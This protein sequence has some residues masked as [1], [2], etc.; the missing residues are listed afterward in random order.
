MCVLL[1]E[2][3]DAYA[4]FVIEALGNTLEHV[5]VT[6]VVRLQ[7]AVQELATAPVDVVLLDLTL[8]DA[9]D[10]LG[11]TAIR[12]AAPDVPLVVLT[13]STDANLGSRVIAAGADDFLQKDPVDANLLVRSIRDARV[14]HTY[15]KSTRQVV[16]EA[17]ARLR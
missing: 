12:T 10:L 7:K 15:R 14:R 4:D 17:I 6:R 9:F 5:C 8:P 16:M 3:D 13:G 2:D 1:V 11:V